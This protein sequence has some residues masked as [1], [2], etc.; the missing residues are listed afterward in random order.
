MVAINI[1]K[2]TKVFVVLQDWE[3]FGAEL[4]EAGVEGFDIAIVSAVTAIAKRF[5]GIP[6]AFD[7]GF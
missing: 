4:F 3:S 6:A 1:N 7:A 5:S 2:K